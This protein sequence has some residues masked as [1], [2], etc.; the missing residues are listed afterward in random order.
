[1]W[2]QKYRIVAATLAECY[3]TKNIT[4]AAPVFVCMGVGRHIMPLVFVVGVTGSLCAAR[5]QLGK[6]MYVAGA[7]WP[8]VQEQR[9]T[10]HQELRKKIW[11][12]Y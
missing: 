9:T 4:G 2:R 3:V 8:D 12:C 10:P 11:P 1:M 5:V 6:H 7:L